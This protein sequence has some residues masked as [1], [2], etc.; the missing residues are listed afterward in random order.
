M[1]LL[2]DIDRNLVHLNL[3]WTFYTPTVNEQGLCCVWYSA[4]WLFVTPWTVASGLLCPWG[5]SRQESWSGLPCPPPGDLP[6]PGFPHCQQILYCLSRQG[7][8]STLEW[9]AYPSPGDLP[10][11]GIELGSPALQVGS[12]P[13]ELPGKNKGLYSFKKEFTVSLSRAFFGGGM[14]CL[15]GH[16]AL[17][18][19]FP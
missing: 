17:S 9:T 12:L 16:P 18:S 6:N 14:E 13:A 3:R 15:L 4:V 2:C 8:P 5:F 19:P 11:S 7:S 10:N 1:Y